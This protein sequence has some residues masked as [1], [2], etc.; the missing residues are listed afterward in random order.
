LRLRVD[1]LVDVTEILAGYRLHRFPSL[2]RFDP[3]CLRRRDVPGLR[4]LGPDDRLADILDG[5]GL[6]LC[7]ASVIDA[8]CGRSAATN[9]NASSPQP[10]A[11]AR[12][13]GLGNA[14][15]CLSSEFGAHTIHGAGGGN[16]IPL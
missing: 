10:N 14:T 6:E 4:R 7:G 9:A 3:S 5:V 12:N 1:Q 2:A 15:T 11:S 13:D 16:T 8:A